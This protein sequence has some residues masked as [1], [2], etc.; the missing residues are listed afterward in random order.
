[1]EVPILTLSYLKRK[2]KRGLLY[3]P[4][5]ELRR[6]PT[7]HKPDL[8]IDICCIQDGQIVLGECKKNQITRKAIDKLNNFSLGLVRNPDRLIFAS[9]SKKTPK[10]IKEYVEKS[11]SLSQDFLMEPD[12]VD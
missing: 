10:G 1:M 6:N 12:L 4:E 3:L 7:A 11:L 2:S 5:V 8:E 9:M